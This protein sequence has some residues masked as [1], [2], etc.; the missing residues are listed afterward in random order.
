MGYPNPN[1][2]W[3]ICSD[4]CKS[5]ENSLGCKGQLNSEWIYEV[6]IS[7][8][9]QTKNYRYFCPNPIINFQGRNLCNFWLGFWEK[10]WPHKFILNLTDLYMVCGCGNSLQ[11][12][13]ILEKQTKGIIIVPVHTH[14][15]HGMHTSVNWVDMLNNK[16]F[17]FSTAWLQSVCTVMCFGEISSGES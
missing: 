13:M 14:C 11:N 8:K 15:T 16:R 4:I 9:I 5:I 17:S 12:W 7:P 10:R 2:T 6:N 3:T 1:G